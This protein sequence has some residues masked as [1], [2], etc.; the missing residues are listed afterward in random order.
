M[1]LAVSGFMVMG[2]V[3]RLSLSNHSDSGSFLV[4]HSL[5]S[6]DGSIEKDSWRFVG[7]VDWCLLLVG[8][9]PLIP[10]PLQYSCLKNPRDGG[11]WWVAVYGV[12]QSW[13]Q[14]KRLSSSSSSS[15]SS[16]SSMFLTRTSCHNPTH[17]N[18]SCGTWP[19]WAVLVSS[20]P[21]IIALKYPWK[22]ENK[23]DMFGLNDK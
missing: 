11:A 14:L 7:H 4:M 3:C 16:I 1:W 2:L 5:L 22:T 21:K 6:Q 20:S 13:T 12:A 19:E 17:A 15:S 18:R 8:G 9:G 10:Y 23:M